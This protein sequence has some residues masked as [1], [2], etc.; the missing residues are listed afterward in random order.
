MKTR[1]LLV[2]WMM[3]GSQAWAC[4]ELTTADAWVRLAPPGAAVMAG[5]LTLSNS[6][7]QSVLVQGASSADFDKA[8]LHSMSMDGGVMQMRKLEL[9]EV[10]VG[11]EIK[12]APGGN[13]LMLIGPKRSFKAGDQI[14]VALNLCE[15]EQ[16][17]VKFTVRES[18]P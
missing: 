17:L 14:D 13:H 1:C 5:Y 8:E 12:L 16:Q 7:E 4:G 9:I 18:A 6:S 10:K 2:G 11:Q 3:F 15:D